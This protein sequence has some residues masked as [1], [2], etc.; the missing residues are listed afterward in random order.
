MKL[1]REIEGTGL[2]CSPRWLI[3]VRARKSTTPQWQTSAGEVKGAGAQ[4]PCMP[5]GSLPVDESYQE[6]GL[7]LALLYL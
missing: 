1:K 2:F 5:L 6:M 4:D 7:A 3:S